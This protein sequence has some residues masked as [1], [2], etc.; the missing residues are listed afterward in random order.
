M[1]FNWP[2][3]KKKGGQKKAE[4]ILLELIGNF[5]LWPS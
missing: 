4:D 5:E 2:R 1:K 3:F